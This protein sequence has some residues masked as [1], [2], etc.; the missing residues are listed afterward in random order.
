MSLEPV[1]AVSSSIELEL[2]QHKMRSPITQNIKIQKQNRFWLGPLV[3]GGFI[4]LGYGLTHRILILS[5]N[6]QKPESEAFNHHLS[7]PGES[8]NE[9]RKRHDFN[10][11]IIKSRF[12]LQKAS[13]VQGEKRQNQQDAGH[14]GTRA[15]PVFKGLGQMCP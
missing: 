13:K 10:G 8:L 5:G 14:G 2:N 9:L 3:A 11:S 7:F 1:C 12:F 15:K 6:W 4:T